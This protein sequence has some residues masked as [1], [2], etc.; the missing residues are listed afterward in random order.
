MSTTLTPDQKTV[1]RLQAA[2]P[3]EASKPFAVI[4]EFETVDQ[5]M[6]AARK[7][8]EAGYTHFDVHTPFPVHGMER[9]MGL[10]PTLLPWLSLMG[11]L[12]GLG[13]AVFLVWW[14]NAIT[15]EDL[16]VS[17]QGYEYLISGKPLFSLPA[18]I[19][20]LFEL[21]ILIT[22]FATVFGMLWLNRLPL[23]YHPLLKSERFSGVTTDRFFVSIDADDPQFDQAK[24]ESFLRE[25]GAVYTEVIED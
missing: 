5:I 6:A 14:T 1:S 2:P 19:P 13:V 25:Q 17:L 16:P 8:R 9:A 7:T 21:T 12:T 10:K 11:G 22:A 4:G 18:N 23:L 3:E 15:V 20:I 24:I